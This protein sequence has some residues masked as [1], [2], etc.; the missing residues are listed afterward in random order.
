MPADTTE[1][2]FL[3]DRHGAEVCSAQAEGHDELSLS[4]EL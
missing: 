2:E 4:T 1:F 3:P